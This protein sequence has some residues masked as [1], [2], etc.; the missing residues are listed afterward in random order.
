[1]NV[2]TRCG[3]TNVFCSGHIDLPIAR[4]DRCYR[5]HG[6]AHRIDVYVLIKF[7]KITLNIFNIKN[8]L[9]LSA[10]EKFSATEKRRAAKKW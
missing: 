9:T 4:K 10:N 6:I 7:K 1:M 2:G 3:I 5:T 8:V